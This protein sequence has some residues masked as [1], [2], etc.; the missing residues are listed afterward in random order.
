MKIQGPKTLR[1]VDRDSPCKEKQKLLNLELT[2][3]KKESW[4][5]LGPGWEWH[6]PL[7]WFYVL[8]KN[9]LGKLMW[10]SF[11]V[12]YSIP[13]IYML[14]PLLILGSG[15]HS[16]TLAWKIPWTEEPGRLQ[17][18]GSQRVRHDWVN[19]LSLFSTDTTQS[20]FFY[21]LKNVNWRL[22]TLQYGGSHTIL[23]TAVK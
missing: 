5:L 15:T 7:G 23:I 9:R 14:L 4:L 6:T 13:F 22:I 11:W 21:F 17:S 16:S 3:I 8:A 20:F 18:T 12:L 2:V 10:A 19:S 1:Q